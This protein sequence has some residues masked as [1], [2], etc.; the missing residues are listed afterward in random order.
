MVGTGHYTG[1]EV[2]RQFQLIETIRNFL[3][4]LVERVFPLFWTQFILYNN[5][6]VSYT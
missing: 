4:V 5:L 1:L 6:S 3:V 2:D